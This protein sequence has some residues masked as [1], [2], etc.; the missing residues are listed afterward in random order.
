MATSGSTNFSVNRDEI[1]E[2]ALRVCGVLDPES[3]SATSTQLTV[4]AQA[5]N[6]IV[7]ALHSDGMPLWA[8]KSKVI[9]LVDGQNTYTPSG[10]SINRPL[11]IIGATRNYTTGSE[12][13][14][15][16]LE[17][18]TRDEYL[19]LGNKDSEGPPVQLY[20]D[21]QLDITGATLYVYPT[22]SSTVASDYTVTIYY[23][24]PFED[25]DASTDTPDFPQEWYNTLKWKLAAEIGFEYGVRGS[26][27][28]RIQQKAEL[29]HMRVMDMG[30]EEGSIYIMPDDRLYH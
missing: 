29:E 25:F 3:G 6:M 18:I 22:P 12:T 2:A 5:L 13:F 4:G 20:Y 24:S 8:I 10:L 11:K 26:M 28:D 1:I 15:S 17:I 30:M 9:T 7:K 14:D 27:L 23:Q 16:N 21:P 19:N